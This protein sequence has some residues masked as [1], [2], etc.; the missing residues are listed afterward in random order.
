MSKMSLYT[1]PGMAWHTATKV[2]GKVCGGFM[3]LPRR[4]RVGMIIAVI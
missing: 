1:I 2:R 3:D 4:G